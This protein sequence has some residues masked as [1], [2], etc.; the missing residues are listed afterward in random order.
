MKEGNERVKGDARRNGNVAGRN[1]ISYRNHFRFS[2]NSP[3][4]MQIS[5]Q[6]AV[7]PAHRNE[8]RNLPRDESFLFLFSPYF[9][10]PLR[11]PLIL[12]TRHTDT[13]CTLSS[14]STFLSNKPK[15]PLRD[16]MHN[17][18]MLVTRVSPEWS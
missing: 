3:R 17:S 14:S 15:S 12:C 7:L 18:L 9:T 10:L 4:S 1:C 8:F 11:L 16:E 2:T 5:L 13:L 6:T